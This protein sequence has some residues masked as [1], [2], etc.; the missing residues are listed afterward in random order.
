VG[1]GWRGRARRAWANGSKK[2]ERLE[3][4]PRCFICG[5]SAAPRQGTRSRGSLTKKV[6]WTSPK[7]YAGSVDLLADVMDGKDALIASLRSEIAS[8]KAPPMVQTLRGALQASSHNRD[9]YY[10]KDTIRPTKKGQM[11]SMP[12][13]SIHTDHSWP[14]LPQ[15]NAM[16]QHLAQ[17]YQLPAHA[18]G[19]NTRRLRR[20]ENGRGVASH[21]HIGYTNYN[22]PGG[23]TT[24]QA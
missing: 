4:A 7:I 10:V 19:E 3:G 2:G 14:H 21:F 12:T 23:S 6:D 22:L 13:P 11:F 18:A 5:P 9:R 1:G 8:L 24:S 20:A 16:P 17:S 15:F